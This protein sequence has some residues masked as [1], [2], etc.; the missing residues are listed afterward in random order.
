MSAHV[1]QLLLLLCVLCNP[2][3][4]MPQVSSSFNNYPISCNEKSCEPT[5]HLFSDTKYLFVKSEAMAI[6]AIG[7]TEIEKNKD[8][9]I[10]QVEEQFFPQTIYNYTECGGKFILLNNNGESTNIKRSDRNVLIEL[11]GLHRNNGDSKAKLGKSNHCG[12]MSYSGDSLNVY[13]TG[14]SIITHECTFD[15]EHTYFRQFAFSMESDC[16]FS[17]V[18]VSQIK[19]VKKYYGVLNS[20]L[21][22]VIPLSQKPRFPMYSCKKMLSKAKLRVPENRFNLI[23]YSNGTKIHC[24][25][26]LLCYRSLVFSR[27]EVKSDVNSHMH[28]EVVEWNDVEIPYSTSTHYKNR[29]DMNI[30]SKSVNQQ[31]TLLVTSI[32]Q[33]KLE[34]YDPIPH[35]IRKFALVFSLIQFLM[36]CC[37][38]VYLTIILIIKIIKTCKDRRMKNKK[39]K[40]NVSINEN[41]GVNM[42][43]LDED[44]KSSNR[45]GNQSRNSNENDLHHVTNGVEFNY[46]NRYN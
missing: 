3:D 16:V 44:S 9:K 2:R 23:R 10:Y 34:K 17:H 30:V 24:K 22:Y 28:N 8:L 36:S 14:G 6:K 1:D 21:N 41:L 46:A 15:I 42:T 38:F 25:S 20:A 13:K 40:R 12:N 45:Q 5:Y 37:F 32:C 26:G 11:I 4:V 39:R 7:E 43:A 18:N 19:C 31:L 33:Y 35:D 29:H 27:N